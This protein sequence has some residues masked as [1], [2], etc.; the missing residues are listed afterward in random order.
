[1][2]R[3]DALPYYVPSHLTANLIKITLCCARYEVITAGLLKIRS[4][5][6]LLSVSAGKQFLTPW[7]NSTG[8]S[9]TVDPEDGST[10]I[11]SDV[12]NC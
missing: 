9:W 10:T 8:T 3:A 5:G 11:L 12:G 1:M 6:M 7:V 2:L 4:C